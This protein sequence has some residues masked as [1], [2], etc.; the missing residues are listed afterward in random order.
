M[1][2]VIFLPQVTSSHP[3]S[4]HVCFTWDKFQPLSHLWFLDHSIPLITTFQ[5]SEFFSTFIT[6]DFLKKFY[7]TL[8]LSLIVARIDFGKQSINLFNWLEEQ[9]GSHKKYTNFNKPGFLHSRK[10]YWHGFVFFCPHFLISF[11]LQF[12]RKYIF[13]LKSKGKIG[14]SF[15]HD[16]SASP[17]HGFYSLTCW[18]L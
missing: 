3:G 13:S 5:I 7:E 18:T 15:K 8:S 2:L 11:S 4:P 6:I 16:N 1:F 10:D 12:S 9:V 17:Y 14:W